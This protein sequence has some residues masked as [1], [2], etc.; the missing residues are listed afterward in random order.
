MATRNGTLVYTLTEPQVLILS[1]VLQ[2]T[3]IY[4]ALAGSDRLFGGTVMINCLRQ[5]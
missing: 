3:I 5:R 2:A 1:S 4:R